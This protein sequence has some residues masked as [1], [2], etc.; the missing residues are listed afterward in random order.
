VE[1]KDGSSCSRMSISELLLVSLNKNRSIR[2]L[3]EKHLLFS[4]NWDFLVNM[5]TKLTHLALCNTQENYSFIIRTTL[6]VSSGSVWYESRLIIEFPLNC[7]LTLNKWWARFSY[8]NVKT[9]LWES[10]WEL[11]YTFTLSDSGLFYVV[12]EQIVI[13]IH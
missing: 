8:L 13:Y 12:Q 7:E 10:D 5:K 11:F 9:I 6:E 3:S 1:E 2:Y 4:D